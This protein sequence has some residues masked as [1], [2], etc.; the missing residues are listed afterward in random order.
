M[1]IHYTLLM[2]FALTVMLLFAAPLA[3]A[4]SVSNESVEEAMF[5]GGCFWCMEHAFDEV[6]GV[7]D[8]ISGYAGG[9]VEHPDY[10][11]VSSGTT[12]HV[13]TVLVRFDPKRVSYAQLLDVFWHNI[14]PTQANGQFCDHGPQYRSVIFYR[15]AAQKRQAEASLNQLQESGILDAPIV[16]EIRE[17]TPFYPAEAYHQ[18]YHHRNPLRYKYYRYLCGRDQRLKQLWG[19]TDG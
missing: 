18:D 16:T 1:L 15:D 3:Q 5:A 6:D 14:D 10:H 11:A 2:G 17:A 12:G 19:K 4:S 9:H 8:T 13:E 7:I